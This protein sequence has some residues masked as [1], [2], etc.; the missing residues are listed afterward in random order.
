MQS[1]THWKGSHPSNL[2]H[3]RKE[4]QHVGPKS[5]T[6]ASQ[7]TNS[8]IRPAVWSLLTH[9]AF[10]KAAGFN[11]HCITPSRHRARAG[12]KPVTRSLSH[13]RT[14]RYNLEHSRQDV[15]APSQGQK[16]AAPPLS[17]SLISLFFDFLDLAFAMPGC[18]E[19][20]RLSKSCA[21][22]PANVETS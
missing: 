22:C 5:S 13:C 9:H 8:T 15:W 3:Q 2:T 21:P 19:I 6:L 11:L 17:R 7:F 20:Q 4:T 16:G 10:L 12:N 1:V 18:P 14:A